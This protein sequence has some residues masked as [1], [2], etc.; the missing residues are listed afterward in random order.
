VSDLG[1]VHMDALRDKQ[2]DFIDVN[3]HMSIPCY[4]G[5]AQ[6]QE[7][8]AVH[9]SSAPPLKKFVLHKTHSDHP[10]FAILVI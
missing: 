9:A 10:V 2:P 8:A 3:T 6:T 5:H 4:P 1:K 7:P